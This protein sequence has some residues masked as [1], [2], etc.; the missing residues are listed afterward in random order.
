[1]WEWL[2]PAVEDSGSI[3]AH[4]DVSGPVRAVVDH[5][6]GSAVGR[7]KGLS[8]WFRARRTVPVSSVSDVV[9]WIVQSKGWPG[10]PRPTRAQMLWYARLCLYLSR[11]PVKGCT[12]QDPSP[13]GVSGLLQI[14]TTADN[15]FQA[16]PWL[17]SGSCGPKG[18]GA[19]CLDLSTSAQLWPHVW[20]AA[21]TLCPD[22]G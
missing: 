4:M 16:S 10:Q 11:Q 9:F 21:S 14:K 12:D 7:N 3:Q 13:V 2:H 15:A 5:Q 6:I 8:V 19:K 1:M 20:R 18:C 17:P 22:W